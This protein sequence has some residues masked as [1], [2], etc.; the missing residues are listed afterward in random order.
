MNFENVRI[1]SEVI[2]R[3]QRARPNIFVIFFLL[4][5]PMHLSLSK[6]SNLLTLNPGL[7]FLVNNQWNPFLSSLSHHDNGHGIQ[8]KPFQPIGTKHFLRYLDSLYKSA[9][10]STDF[11]FFKI[12]CTFFAIFFFTKTCI[13]VNRVLLVKCGRR[14]FHAMRHQYKVKANNTQFCINDF[15][16]YERLDLYSNL[17]DSPTLI[18]SNCFQFQSAGSEF[19]YQIIL[20]YFD[21]TFQRLFLRPLSLTRPCEASALFIRFPKSVFFA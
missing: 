3:I 2:R 21:I 12:Q 17:D 20:N 5:L 10:L 18:Y 16:S 8:Q 13:G 6:N 9:V 11:H 15:S 7:G 4:V 14:G 19:Y 1:L